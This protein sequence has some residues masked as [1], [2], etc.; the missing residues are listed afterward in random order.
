MRTTM[1]SFTLVVVT[2]LA[3]SGKISFYIGL[4]ALA[5][6]L[7]GIKDIDGWLITGLLAWWIPSLLVSTVLGVCISH[8]TDGLRRASREEI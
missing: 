6:D 1:L 8:I 2:L 5:I 7:L 3:L 4:A